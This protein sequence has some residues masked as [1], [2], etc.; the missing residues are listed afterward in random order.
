MNDNST[1]ALS[2]PN[3]L[4]PQEP[5]FQDMH[6]VVQLSMLLYT[7]CSSLVESVLAFSSRRQRL[8]ASAFR[9]SYL[10]SGAFL[11]VAAARTVAALAMELVHKD[12][13]H[14][15]L[16]DRTFVR[17]VLFCAIICHHEALTGAHCPS[18]SSPFHDNL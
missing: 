10:E 12:A 3:P 11:F 4:Q 16:H 7:I 2:S 17:T 6:R 14:C 13:S 1:S 9:M 5:N 18:L 15:A 8:L